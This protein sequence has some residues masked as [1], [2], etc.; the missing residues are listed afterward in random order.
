MRKEI[1]RIKLLTF[2]L[3]EKKITENYFLLI[4]LQVLRFHLS[5]S[6]LIALKKQNK[7][8]SVVKITICSWHYSKTTTI[9][10]TEDKRAMLVTAAAATTGTRMAAIDMT[11]NGRQ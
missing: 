7:Q 10:A 4:S 6:Q 9:A 8:Q 1:G 5:T 11:N 2:H 3:N